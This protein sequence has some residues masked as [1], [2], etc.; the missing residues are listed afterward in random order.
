MSCCY[1]SAAWQNQFITHLSDLEQTCLQQKFQ[2]RDWSSCTCNKL[3]TCY[4]SLLETSFSSPNK[5]I[6]LHKDIIKWG[7]GEGR[8]LVFGVYFAWV[9]FLRFLLQLG[10]DAVW[11]KKKKFTAFRGF[12]GYASGELATFSLLLPYHKCKTQSGV[13]Y[14]L[15][16][17]QKVHIERGRNCGVI[18][19]LWIHDKAFL[20]LACLAIS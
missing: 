16:T 15:L 17:M 2:D 11:E 13:S 3:S 4:L 18:N 8:V 9:G 7:G 1:N 5:V 14:L 12:A 20:L 6:Y 10:S 19:E